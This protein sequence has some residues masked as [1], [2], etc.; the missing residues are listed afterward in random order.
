M[1]LVTL[2]RRARCALLPWPL[3]ATI[4]AGMPA[5]AQPLPTEVLV[6]P[7]FIADLEFDWGRDGVF[8]ASC[9]GGAGNARFTFTDKN[10]ELWVGGIDPATGDFVPRNGRGVRVDVDA[11][12]AVD[13][14]NGPEWVGTLQGSKIVY[15]KYLAG[16][17]KV[18][19]NAGLGV[20]SFDGTTWAAGFVAN[21]MG[22]YLPT[23]SLDVDD[24]NPRIVYQNGVGSRFKAYA[25]YLDDPASEVA[26]PG[27]KPVCSR[28]WVAATQVLIYT[29]PCV[30]RQDIGPPAQVYWHDFATGTVEQV[31]TDPSVKLYAFAWRAP[32]FDGDYAIVSVADRTSI[33]VHRRT[34]TPEGSTWQLVKTIAA[35][36]TAPYITSPDV[37]VHN[38]RSHVVFQISPSSQATNYRVATHLAITGIDPEL[39][40]LRVLTSDTSA[41]RLRLDPEYYITDAGPVLYYNRYVPAT[42]TQPVRLEGIWRIDLGLGPSIPPGAASAARGAR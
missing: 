27:N 22:R 11:A 25:R 8:C 35:P 23:G 9:N 17:P 18:P 41:V 1:I 24:P 6:T 29:A 31:T 3:L 33:V 42:A 32:E 36:L 28:R 30:A 38:G 10:N 26:L 7:T 20:A 39:S 37:L 12:Q 34:D 4:A 14:G 13:F 21:G 5:Q 40:D 2:L 15:M 19:E 16:L